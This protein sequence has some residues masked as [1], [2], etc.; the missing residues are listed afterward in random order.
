MGTEKNSEPRKVV[1]RITIEKR[2]WLPETKTEWVRIADQGDPLYGYAEHPG[3]TIE[4]TTILVQE[5]DP[6]HFNIRTVIKAVNGL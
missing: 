6:Q 2:E 4:T 5:L 3:E 1:Y